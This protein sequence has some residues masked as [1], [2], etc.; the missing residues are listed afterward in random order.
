MDPEERRRRRVER[1]A[2]AAEEA[3]ARSRERRERWA[4]EAMYISWKGYAAD[5]TIA[6]SAGGY[7]GFSHHRVRSLSNVATRCPG[8]TKFSP[9]SVTVRTNSMIF[10]FTHRRS[11]MP[12]RWP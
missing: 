2:R 11:N 6:W 9:G 5:P 1:E 3:D 10:D 8:G 7:V 4:G 12:T